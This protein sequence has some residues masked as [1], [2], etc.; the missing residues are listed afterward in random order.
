[1]KVSGLTQFA[2]TGQTCIAGS[3]LLVQ[4][5]I[6]DAFVDKLVAFG[7]ELRIDGNVVE[8]RNAAFSVL[9]LA[10]LLRSF[11]ARRV[12]PL[13]RKRADRKVARR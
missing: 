8:A 1:M 7:W 6:H 11:G 5:S 9:V 10:E 4:K 13:R 12:R 2:A 3:R